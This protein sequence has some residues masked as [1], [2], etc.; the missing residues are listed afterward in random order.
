MRVMT[1]KLLHDF[2]VEE[3]IKNAD[4]LDGLSDVDA[5]SKFAYRVKLG[6]NVIKNEKVKDILSKAIDK[7]FDFFL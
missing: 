3:H 6:L 2:I 7:A 1:Q 5:V 4:S